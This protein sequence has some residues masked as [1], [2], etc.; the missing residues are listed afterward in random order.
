TTVSS[1]TVTN[2]LFRTTYYL[3]VRATNSFGDSAY[4][5]TLAATVIPS[6]VDNGIDL[7]VPAGSTYTLAGS[8]SYTNSVVVNGTLLV[9]PLNGTASG[10][11]EL[12]APL[13]HVSAGGV[14]SADGAGFLSGQGPGA[15]YT[16]SAGPFS[17]GGG[18]GGGGFGG[19]GGV[20]DRFHATSGESYGS[21]TQ[22][23]DMGSGGGAIN[24]ILGGRGGGRIRI[25]A[26]TI[27]VDG[28]VSAEGLNGAE[29][30]G[31]NFRVAGG[32]GAGGAVRLAA[33][34]LEG[35]GAIAA[36]GGASVSPDREGGG[37]SGGRIVATFNSSTFN[38][39]VSARGGVG[40]Q[41]GG[42]GTAVYGGEL[43]VENTAPGAVTTIPSGSYSFDTVRIAT[44]AV[45]EL[46]SAAAVTAATLI[47]EG[48][49]LLNLYIG[50]IDA[51]QV[52]VRSGARLRYAA[53]SLTATGLAVSSS[54]VFTLN[55]NLSLS[56]MSVLAGGLVTH[57]T[58][59]TGFDLS[60]S[61]TLTVE[62]GGRVS[63]AGV[64]HP[65]LQGP[66]AGYLVNAGQFDGQRGGGGGGYGGLGGAADRFHALSGATYGSLTQPS[67]L[68]S[69]GGTAN[70]NAGG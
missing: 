62:A 8:R 13:V 67:D 59:E 48:P 44:N 38:G 70:G 41:Q 53:G 42:A 57:E 40:W 36:D 7:I 22:S 23:L 29:N 26:N 65:S 3:R 1:A 16:T 19:N 20:G 2:L 31:S 52:D 5:T 49:A 11:L 34:T 43:R 33:S 58:T 39:T 64:G 46:T 54:A 63:A 14:L 6:V 56:Q 18:G 24:G 55:K 60:V 66:G 28:R 27:R 21:V 37:G 15:G 51:Q 25:T 12:S 47:V 61:G 69:G 17:D 35:S 45:V 9:S 32:G 30:V 4:S 10:F 50:A 68:G